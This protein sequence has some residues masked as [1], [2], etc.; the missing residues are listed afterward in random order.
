MSL[1]ELLAPLTPA[2]DITNNAKGGLALVTGEESVESS[3]LEAWQ[4]GVDLL[5]KITRIEESSFKELQSAIAEEREGLVNG[6]IQEMN[7]SI[8]RHLN[9]SRW[10]SQIGRATCR[11]RVCPYV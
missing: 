1:R 11:E 5:V 2:A 10:W 6:L 3:R 7:N 4:L 8:A 9:V